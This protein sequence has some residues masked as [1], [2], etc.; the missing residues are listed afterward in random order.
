MRC[1]LCPWHC[2]PKARYITLEWVYSFLTD[3]SR[4]TEEGPSLWKCR[5]RT[6]LPFMTFFTAIYLPSGLVHWNGNVIS[7]TKYSHQKLS[8]SPAAL[9][10]RDTN[11]I[12]ILQSVGGLVIDCT[13]MYSKN[14]YIDVFIGN[15]GVEERWHTF[16]KYRKFSKITRTKSQNLNVSHLVLQLFCAIYWHHM[17]SG[18]WRCS[19]SSADRRCSNYIWGINSCIAY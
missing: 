4:L 13:K 15:G 5:W 6:C 2:I 18:E 14:C 16:R 12:Y 1:Q 7:L 19:W 11:S 17:L 9:K 10:G 3:G 8:K